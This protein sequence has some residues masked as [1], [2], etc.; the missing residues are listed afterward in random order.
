MTVSSIIPVNNYAGNSSSTT[1]DFDFLIEKSSELTVY[2]TDE[3]GVIT[4]L[5]EGTD[6][7]INEIGNSSGSYITYPLSTSAHEVL[8]SE[9]TITL[10]LDLVIKQ[11]NEFK[12]SLY[13]N[14]DVLEWTFDYII[15]ILQIFSRKLDRAVLV[16]EGSETE[17]A[18]LLND[19]KLSEKNAKEYS[20]IAA[21]Q[22]EISTE[23]VQK[24]LQ[25]LE[26][27]K[28]TAADALSDIEDARLESLEAISQAEDDA[29][30]N[31]EE[32]TEKAKEWAVKMGGTV[33]GTY[34]SARYYA[35]E[36]KNHSGVS[37]E[38]MIASNAYENSGEILDDLEGYT[39][40][41]KYAHSTFDSSKLTIAG[42]PVITDEG[43]AAGFS[44]S[45]YIDSA[46]TIEISAA[47][48][49]E[50]HITAEMPEEAPANNAFLC[51][52]GAHFIY[53]NSSFEL[54]CTDESN[55]SQS[56]AFYPEIGETYDLIFGKTAE[57]IN[58][59][60]Y[61]KAL[62]TEYTTVGTTVSEGANTTDIP[63]YI[64]GYHLSRSSYWTGSV[65]LSSIRIY[66]DGLL[67]YSFNKTGTDTVI[68]N[69]EK[70]EIPYTLSITGSKIV[71]STYRDVIQSYYEQYNY[72]PY[73]TIDEI[74][75]N[76]TLPMGELYGIIENKNEKLYT[77]QIKEAVCSNTA[78]TIENPNRVFCTNDKKSE[79][80]LTYQSADN[81]DYIIGT[82][83]CTCSCNFVILEGY[84]YYC[85]EDNVLAKIGTSNKW[86]AVSGYYYAASSSLVYFANGIC[87]G[88]LYRLSSISAELIS[89]NNTWSC[90]C[91][92]SGFSGGDDSVYAYAIC[93]GELYMISNST[94]PTVTRLDDNN[95]WSAI[96]GFSSSSY[97][98]LGIRNNQLYTISTD[99]LTSIDDVTSC[100]LIGGYCYPGVSL[101]Y[102]AYFVNNGELYSL[103][104]KDS[105]T[106]ITNLG[107]SNC[108]KLSGS[109]SYS[110]DSYNSYA[111]AI[112]DGALY[113][114]LENTAAQ[115][116][117]DITWSDVAGFSISYGIN[118]GKLYRIS[119]STLTEV[120]GINNAE[121]VSGGSTG[122][123]V[124]KYAKT[125][126]YGNKTAY[127][128]TTTEANDVTSNLGEWRNEDNIPNKTIVTNG[129]SAIGDTI[130]LKYEVNPETII[131]NIN[132]KLEKGTDVIDGRWHLA[133]ADLL[134]ATAIGTYTLDLSGY[135]PDDNYDYE[136]SIY[137]FVLRSDSS[138]TNSGVYIYNNDILIARISIDDAASSG[139]GQTVT[140]NTPILKEKQ[141]LSVNIVNKKTNDTT[142]R[143]VAYRRMGTNG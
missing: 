56:F 47:E 136:V 63:F 97:L 77:K 67:A 131:Q 117:T 45:D 86:T 15:R 14:F 40:I 95:D 42:S 34:Y 17:P 104:V 20:Q 73:Y 82:N 133:E 11:E 53:L 12:N 106:T 9:E 54:F 16:A 6:Y 18:E 19:I 113:S 80:T 101:D 13:F 115:I 109:I 39:Y 44:S 21:E 125:F 52:I 58:Y 112:C 36:S 121:A 78:L 116:G 96:C 140:F 126:A 62:D 25:Y 41:K 124:V 49:Y 119:G 108:T 127:L 28:Q 27:T 72:A 120:D 87:D 68:I 55:S 30:C 60:K 91:G 7:S 22:A 70:V 76:F 129:N 23:N 37:Y 3:D 8:S 43:I 134:T 89:S 5:E 107:L 92:Y 114:L 103:L 122:N 100:S 64:S 61:K 137:F 29:L 88:K 98:A 83:D 118:N 48:S 69:K 141:E 1:F 90:V 59:F 132:K 33:D 65:D 111:Y 123:S 71:E 31:V 2:L 99:T 139:T 143:A 24:T 135:L 50:V 138:S 32:S 81:I 75:N 38:Q 110:A 105:E 84:L 26:D 57:Y 35:E 130:T 128:I 142:I 4:L 79:E 10:A 85:S 74:N 94:S 66:L 51:A 93:N 46:E 102:Y